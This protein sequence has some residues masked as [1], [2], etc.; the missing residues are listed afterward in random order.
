MQQAT[1]KSTPAYLTLAKLAAHPADRAPAN[2]G[3]INDDFI[4]AP[5]LAADFSS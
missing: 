5:F 3:N 2:T 1:A 4:S